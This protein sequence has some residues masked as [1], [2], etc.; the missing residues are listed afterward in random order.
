MSRASRLHVAVL[1]A[2]AIGTSAAAPPK[3]ADPRELLAKQIAAEQQ[4]LATTIDTV[5]GKLAAAD[6]TRLHRIHAAMRVLHAPLPDG[7]TADERMA[8]ARRR[9]A[10][11]LLLE[12]DASE[13]ALLANETEHLHVS[14][15]ETIEAG[16]QIS[17]LQLPQ[18]LEVPAKGT[19]ARHFGEYVHER[20]KA[21]LSRRGIDL[22]VEDHAPAT[23][24]ADGVVRYAG[25]IRGLDHGVILDH[26]DFLTVIAKL[27]DLTLPIGTHV[28]RGDRLGR[29]A[30]HR[31]YLEV[32]AKV[33]PGGLPIDPEPLFAKR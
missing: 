3:P 24:P 13:R 4:T 20:S 27:G 8:V 7:A 10:A 16:E 30:H 22:E 15:K 14:E 19:V 25:V 1:S 33:G 9:A 29:A 18:A 5:N 21:T 28:A 17:K 11:K 31:V 2:M 26:G 23:A 32:R 6:T 12:R